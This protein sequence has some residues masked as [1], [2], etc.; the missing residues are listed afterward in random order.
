MHKTG[1]SDA[2]GKWDREAGLF[3]ITDKEAKA[4]AR[5]T[6]MIS[7]IQDLCCLGLLLPTG[8]TTFLGLLLGVCPQVIVKP[9][10]QA[11]I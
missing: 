2:L 9:A 4:W 7:C 11:L 6:L 5:V 10:F 8:P 1:N 3:P